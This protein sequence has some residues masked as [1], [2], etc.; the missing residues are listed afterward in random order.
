MHAEAARL[1]VHACAHVHGR[2]AS[3]HCGSQHLMAPNCTAIHAATVQQSDWVR[4]PCCAHQSMTADS[5]ID[6]IAQP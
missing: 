1:Q 4:E 5:T 3:E 2:T 6:W